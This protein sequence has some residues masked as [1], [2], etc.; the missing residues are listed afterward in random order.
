MII[1]EDDKVKLWLKEDVK[2]PQYI[3]ILIKNGYDDMEC[4]QHI[5]LDEMQQIGID[6]MGH[7]HKILRY[8]QKLKN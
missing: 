3:D 1:S 7:R 4:I 5:T 6:K 2:L 8:A